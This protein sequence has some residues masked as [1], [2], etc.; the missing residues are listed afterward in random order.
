MV[1]A[2]QVLLSH[3]QRMDTL[4]KSQWKTRLDIP[5]ELSQP[6][7]RMNLMNIG[8]VNQER[9]RLMAESG[10]R[11]DNQTHKNREGRNTLL[12][13]FSFDKNVRLIE[14]KI[15]LC[16]RILKG[17]LVCIYNDCMNINLVFIN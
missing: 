10:L 4:L 1:N 7:G 13:F 5:K 6:T 14:F 15:S 11:L 2:S 3:V 8:E 9:S 12:L 17:F 16:F